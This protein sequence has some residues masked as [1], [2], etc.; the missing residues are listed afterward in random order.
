MQ[1]IVANL[2]FDDQ[3]EEA[4][5]FYVSVFPNSSIGAIARYTE[6]VSEAAGRPVGSVMTVAFTLNRQDFLGLNGGPLFKFSEAVSF[7]IE[8]DS[9]DEID[10]YW[11]KLASDGGQEGVCG[12][13]KDRFGLSWQ[14]VPAEWNDMAARS[15]PEQLDR[16]MK[17]LLQ[18]KKLEIEP[19]RKAFE[20]A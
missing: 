11:S 18:M 9:Q 14:L 19:L 13:L 4:A 1:K 12:W 2:W 15:T 7:I 6:S 3:A 20:G 10:Y 17:A 5:K 16:M 8:C